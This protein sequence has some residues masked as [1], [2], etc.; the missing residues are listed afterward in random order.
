M[1]KTLKALLVEDNFA[2]ARL[3][4]ELL[5]EARGTRF[6]LEHSIRLSD[7]L[8][9]LA[10]MQYDVV[11]LDLGLPDSQGLDTLMR[12]QK[13]A[14]KVPI[15]VLT[16][17]DDE[18]LAFK[19]IRMDAQDYIV[20]GQADSDLLVR[21]ILYAIERKRTREA[22]RESEE[23]YRELVENANSI[24]LKVD[25]SG[26]ITFFNEFAQA[27]FGFAEHEIA[28][29][30]IVGTIVPYQDSSGKDLMLMVKE[31]LQDPDRYLKNENENIRKDGTRVWVA[32]TNKAMRDSEG[33]I[34]GI[35][36]VGQDIS[37]RRKMEEIIRQQASHD[38]LTGLPNRRMF[39]DR[40][41]FTLNQAHRYH[42]QIAVIFMDLDHFKN[43]ND[44]LGHDAG[45]QLLKEVA[46]RLGYCVRETDTIARIGGD[47]FNIL[48]PD[49]YHAEDTTIIVEKIMAAFQRPFGI[50]GHEF[51]ITASIGISIY[52]DDGQYADILLKNADAAMYHVKEQGRNN[53]QFYN[54]AI[55][56]RTIERM[57]LEKNLRKTLECGGLVV[58]YQ[59]QVDMETK[60]IVCAEALVRWQHPE[61]GLLNPI[62]FI[63]L[64]EE[65][66]LIIPVGKWVLSAACAQNKAWQEAG[67]PPL[68]VTVNLSARQFQQSNLAEMVAQ[69]L[70][71]TNL[72]AEWLELEITES[73]AMQDIGYTLPNLSRLT[74]MGIRFA[75]DDFGTGCTS[76]SYLKSLPVQKLKIDRSFIRGL[77]T[78]PDDQAIVNAVI[79]LA[80]NLR[81]KVVAEGVETEDQ[82]L[83]LRSSQCDE[84]QGYLLSKPLPVEEFEKLMV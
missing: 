24:I 83:F 2:Y 15:I 4:R 1:D 67:Y 23:K 11:L 65:T 55:N 59:P 61:L 81:L 41:F 52:P 32:W 13:Q 9:R 43:V 10:E 5:A 66:G 21:S 82:F 42:K 39:M 69:V 73:T 48:L 47:E 14:P 63:P 20:K 44:S 79:A 50:Q 78:D 53:Y 49:I 80:H 71:E 16:G 58:Y 18:E 51:H 3:I 40:L 19:A 74:E 75:I 33:R 57:I 25:T 28:G 17:L 27:F 6:V 37:E 72:D 36:A 54:P 60:Q 76:L 26:T 31:I 68:C 30:N 62:K 84:V 56:V 64:A 7:G 70:H 12:V 22:L 34:T 29:K 38:A 45:D 35:L 46:E 8:M 77:T